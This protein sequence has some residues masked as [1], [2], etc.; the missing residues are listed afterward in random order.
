MHV[1]NERK[2]FTACLNTTAALAFISAYFGEGEGVVVIDNIQCTGSESR[3]ID[4]PHSDSNGDTHSKDA[5]VRC[6]ID[7][8]LG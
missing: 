5:G 3:L 7:K 1:C 8:L 4:C 2:S 6:F